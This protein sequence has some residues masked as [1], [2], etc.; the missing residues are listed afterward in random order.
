M[1]EN[2]ELGFTLYPR[3]RR[4]PAETVTD[5]DFVDDIAPLADINQDTEALLLILEIAAEAVSLRINE[6]KTE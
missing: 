5:A 4:F 3:S 2:T 6:D 1:E